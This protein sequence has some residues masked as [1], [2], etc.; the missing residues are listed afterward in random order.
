MKKKKC[1]V[2]NIIIFIVEMEICSDMLRRSV[3]GE[4]PLGTLSFQLD[5]SPGQT[6]ISS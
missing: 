2:S 5:S 3:I 4:V 6:K 1:D